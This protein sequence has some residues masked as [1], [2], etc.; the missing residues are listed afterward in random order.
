MAIIFKNPP[1]SFVQFHN[2]AEDLVHFDSLPVAEPGDLVFQFCIVFDSLADADMAFNAAPSNYKLWLLKSR[3]YA[4]DADLI[5]AKVFDY[6]LISYSLKLFRVS[7][8]IIVFYWD[9]S[10]INVNTLLK[11]NECFRLGL[12]MTINGT[13]FYKASNKFYRACEIE[14]TTVLEYY[15]D[16]DIYGFK[17]CQFDLFNRVRIPMLLDQPQLPDEESVYPKSDGTLVITKSVTK[18]EFEGSTQHFYFKTHE[19]IKIALSHDQVFATGINVDNGIRKNGNYEIKWTNNRKYI[20]AP[21]EFKAF[22]TPYLVRN[23]NCH[24][25]ETY[26]RC[27]EINDFNGTVTVDDEETCVPVVIPGSMILPAAVVGEP[28]T[29]N[30]NL[31]GTAPFS[32]SSIVNPSWASLSVVGSTVQI[33]GTPTSTASDVPISFT[34]NN[35]DGENFDYSSSI[36]IV[37]L[38]FVPTIV[39]DGETPGFGSCYKNIYL[40]FDTNNDHLS[41]VVTILDIYTDAQMF[42]GYLNEPH[43]STNLTV[44]YST[45]KQGNGP[46]GLTRLMATVGH[47]SSDNKSG[48]KINIVQKLD[49]AETGNTWVFDFVINDS[50][51]P[52]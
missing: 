13:T 31:L 45:T 1:Y 20:K 34:V 24:D 3:A 5:A 8:T 6:S 7:D 42:D 30:I 52:C 22:E 33:T 29:Y 23:D 25:C 17:Y 4:D 19:K 51:E 32:I 49:G 11:C 38:D 37:E 48:T 28:Y 21:A 26:I 14:Y 27:G 10:L 43:G 40:D 12:E 2:A 39:E 18:K 36:D 9:E 41:Y 44:G 47:G 35:C 16:E 46:A 50:S 15:G